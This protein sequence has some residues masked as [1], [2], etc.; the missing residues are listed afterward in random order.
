VYTFTAY[1]NKGQAGEESVEHIFAEPLD[2]V[3]DYKEKTCEC[4]DWSRI[5]DNNICGVDPDELEVEL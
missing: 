4:T 2:V 3:Y 1:V 5:T